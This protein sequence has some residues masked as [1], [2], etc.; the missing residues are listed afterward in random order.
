M[1]VVKQSSTAAYDKS[2]LLDFSCLPYNSAAAV[3]RKS[4]ANHLTLM[5]QEAG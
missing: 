5:P 3:E 2:Y 1:V 4:T